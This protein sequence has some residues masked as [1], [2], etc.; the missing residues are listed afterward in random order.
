MSWRDRPYAGD[1]GL[2][3]E[4]RLQFRRPSTVVGSII[5]LNVVI[6]AIDLISQNFVGQAADQ[7]FGLSLR[8]LARLLVWQPITYMFLHGGVMHLLL[9]MLMIYVCGTEFERAFGGRRFIQFYAM[10]GM[11]GGLAY[12]GLAAVNP[13]YYH[14]PLIGASGAAYG[15]V[16]AAII[17]FPHIQ[18]I[19]FIIPVP[20]RV[21]GLIMLALLLFEL[22]SPNGIDNPG[23]EVCHVAGA[24]TGLAI[25]YAW[26]IMPVIRFGSGRGTAGRRWALGR[27]EGAWARKQRKLVD[28]QAEVDRILAKVHEQGIHSLTR[29]ERK[30]LAE[31]TQRQKEQERRLDRVERG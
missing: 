21:F 8:G 9:N 10:C 18:V 23:G 30:V 3:P 7:V 4:L 28:E 24:A 27:K 26:G 11:V 15:L 31:A 2:R 13:A 16:M 5:V 12:L 19:L 25:F 1:E 29:K 20:I 6:F 22:V 14:K 17:L